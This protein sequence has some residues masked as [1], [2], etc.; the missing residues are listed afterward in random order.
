[1][2]APRKNNATT[3]VEQWADTQ[4]KQVIGAIALAAAGFFADEGGI[5]YVSFGLEG[6]PRTGP[7]EIIIQRKEGK[8]AHELRG[9][10]ESTA[11]SLRDLVGDLLNALRSATPGSSYRGLKARA[12]QVA[13]EST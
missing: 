11:A 8:T 3:P 10:A 5:N 4:P 12:A 2:T 1:M 6:L 13:K 9:E 7:L